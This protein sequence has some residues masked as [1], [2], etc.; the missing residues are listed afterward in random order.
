M[1]RKWEIYRL[2]GGKTAYEREEKAREERERLASEYQTA[3]DEAKATNLARYEDILKQYGTRYGTAVEDLAKSR[4]DITGR[5]ASTREDVLGGLEGLGEAEKSDIRRTYAQSGS[6]AAQNLI[7]SGLHS[8]TISPAVQRQ[9]VEAM[10]RTL[11]RTEENLRREKLGYISNLGAQEVSALQGLSS[12]ELGYTTGLSREKLDFMERR[13]DE[14]P[15]QNTYL[16]L[17]QQ[18]GNTGS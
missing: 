11:G 13:T 14:Y 9:N 12:R 16:Q 4:E 17:M 1:S 10:Q 18:L 15:E 2:A 7:S 6:Q 5:L 3:Y 8:T